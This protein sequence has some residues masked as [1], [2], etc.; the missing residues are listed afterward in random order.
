MWVKATPN[1]CTLEYIRSEDIA[2]VW[3]AVPP[4]VF[5][6]VFTK[7]RR[8]CRAVVERTLSLVLRCGGASNVFRALGNLR[9]PSKF[10][11]GLVNCEHDAS[12]KV[13]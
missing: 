6:P 2:R 10:V 11:L 4:D 13:F 5:I 1:L 9:P 12:Q 3:S 7:F 8:I